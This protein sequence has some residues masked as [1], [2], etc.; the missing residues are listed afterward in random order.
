MVL[1]GITQFLVQTVKG[2]LAVVGW[3]CCF[4]C[5]FSVCFCFKEKALFERVDIKWVGSRERISRA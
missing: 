3:L 4:L 2:C 1:L 5:V